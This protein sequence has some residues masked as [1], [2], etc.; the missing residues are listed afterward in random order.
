M[1]PKDVGTVALTLAAPPAGVP[2]NKIYW[3]AQQN[4]ADTVTASAGDTPVTGLVT[5]G[6]VVKGLPTAK[7]STN[8]EGSFNVFA[9]RD[10]NGTGTYAANDPVLAVVHVAIV[11]ITVQL[12]S[13][14]VSNPGQFRAYPSGANIN[15][16]TRPYDP[17]TGTLPK[18]QPSAMNDAALATGLVGFKAVVLVEGGGANERIGTDG[19]ILGWIQDITVSDITIHYGTGTAT[20]FPTSVAAPWLDSA[21][22]RDY[23][24]GTPAVPVQPGTGGSSAFVRSSTDRAT[25]VPITDLATGGQ[26]RTVMSMECA[27]HLLPRDEFAN[28]QP[29]E[30]Y[31]GRDGVRD[32][33]LGLQHGLPVELR[34]LGQSGLERTICRDDPGQ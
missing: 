1:L 2:L 26:N 29:V 4:P 19:I 24:G 25:D 15:L 7:L 30:E 8:T 22:D 3:T 14:V 20:R 5:G 12:T 21:R 34:R 31:R 10:V 13:K 28:I 17:R 11:R 6:G 27:R 18:V 9:F 33:P 32:V 16:D 23:K